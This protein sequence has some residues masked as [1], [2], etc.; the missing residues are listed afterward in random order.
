[1]ISTGKM[2]VELSVAVEGFAWDPSDAQ[3]LPD[4]PSCASSHSARNK[5]GRV[6]WRLIWALFFR[7]SP[8]I[9][10]PWRRFLLRLFGASIGRYVHVHPSVKVWA[11]WN[12]QMED[13]SCLGPDVDCYCVNRI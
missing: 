5:M 3:W 12:L 2:D 13:H 6:I 10:H 11:P 9:L 7:P 1:M 8:K 4:R